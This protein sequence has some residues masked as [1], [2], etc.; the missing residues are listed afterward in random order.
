MSAS[1][2]FLSELFLSNKNRSI[3]AG[4]GGVGLLSKHLDLCDFEVRLVNFRIALTT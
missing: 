4:N 2:N 1:C 3:K